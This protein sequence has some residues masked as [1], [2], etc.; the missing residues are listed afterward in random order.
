MLSLQ[1]GLF[2]RGKY[3]A[4][5]RIGKGNC[6]DEGMQ[7]KKGSVIGYVEQL[8]THVAIEVRFAHPT[9]WWRWWW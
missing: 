7:V 6:I 2:R 1:V 8:G 4:G 5:K 3:A 9:W